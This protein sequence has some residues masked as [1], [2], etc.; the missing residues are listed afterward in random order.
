VPR[1]D[2]VDADGKKIGLLDEETMG[3]VAPNRVVDDHIA[4][5]KSMFMLKNGISSILT[6]SRDK[7][8]L[9]L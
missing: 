1:V 4:S 2:I 6:V 8:G 3:V 9:S 7:K 5:G